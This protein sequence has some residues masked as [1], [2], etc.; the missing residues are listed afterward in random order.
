MD[1]RDLRE[2]FG[3]LDEPGSLRFPRLLTS[4]TLD[5]DR[6]WGWAPLDDE[7]CSTEFDAPVGATL[8]VES[9]FWSYFSETSVSVVSLDCA[10]SEIDCHSKGSVKPVPVPPGG[11]DLQVEYA[12]RQSY[13]HFA[14]AFA[15]RRVPTAHNETY[16]TRTSVGANT[17]SNRF[18][19]GWPTSNIGHSVFASKFSVTH[20]YGHLKTLVH[21]VPS[22][23]NAQ[24]DY[25][26]GGP[27]DCTLTWSAESTEWQSAAAIEGFA[28]FFA[29]L[30][31]NDVSAAPRDGVKAWSVSG[32]QWQCRY[33][34]DTNELGEPTLPDDCILDGSD[35]T[36]I[37]DSWHHQANCEPDMCP[38]GVA[39]ASDWAFALWDMRVLTSVPSATL[40]GLLSLSYPW[41]VNGTSSTYFD[42]FILDIAGG[43][44]NGDDLTTW[45]TVSHTRGID[46]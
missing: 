15:E 33:H 34:P 40:L 19:G 14:A 31:W 28:D 27:N 12:T 30:V 37:A 2:D 1:G 38:S 29:M 3:R 4:V 25:C 45:L 10:G 23:S 35:L 42:E 36:T 16:C 32:S 46:R 39:T 6:I 17:I 5:G 13:I 18:A 20:E 22:F 9:Y 26:Y 24:A 11:G 7:G 43:G 41:K 8:E 21:S 44:L